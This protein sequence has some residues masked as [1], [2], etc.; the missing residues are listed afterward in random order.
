MLMYKIDG[1][2]ITQVFRTGEEIWSQDCIEGQEPKPE[3]QIMFWACFT[4]HRLQDIRL[5]RSKQLLLFLCCP[6]RRDCRH[7]CRQRR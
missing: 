5:L 6:R 7:W 1:K 3:V 2:G 4:G